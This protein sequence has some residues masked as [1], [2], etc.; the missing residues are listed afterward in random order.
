MKVVKRVIVGVLVAAL[1]AGGIYT[2][3]MHVKES[4]VT[5]VPVTSVSNLQTDWYS[6][7]TLDGTITTNVSQNVNM[8]KD[9]IIEK[10]YVS[11]GDDVKKGDN[12]ISFDMT[13]VEMELNIAKLKQQKQEQDLTKAQNR[14]TSLQNG[15]PVEESDADKGALDTGTTSDTDTE[16]TGDD[17]ASAGGSLN[18]IYLAAVVNPILA[19]AIPEETALS[20]DFTDTQQETVSEENAGAEVDFNSD[21][22]DSDNSE[23]TPTPEA[24]ETPGATEVPDITLTPGAELT[25][26]PGADQSQGD[27]VDDIKIIDLEPNQNKDKLMDGESQFVKVLDDETEPIAGTGRMIRLCFCVIHQTDM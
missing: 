2:G 12:L 9:M 19:A 20:E 18:G 21:D 27:F 17:L 14:L 13:L 24:T 1:A 22:T 25:P 26:T 3:L 11:Q 5:E 6:E 15:G 7:T 8:D 16:S 23:P 10:I 4:K